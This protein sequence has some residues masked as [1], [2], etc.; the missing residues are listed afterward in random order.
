LTVNVC[1][2]I[3]TVPARAA[4]VFAA[5]LIPTEPLPVPEAPDVTVIHG[6]ALTDVHAHAAV[7]VTATVEVLAFASTF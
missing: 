5:M 2:A 3:V 4:P 6:A 7:V 1:P